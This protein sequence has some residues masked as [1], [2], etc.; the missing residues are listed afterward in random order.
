MLTYDT[1]KAF[2]YPTISRPPGHIVK[3]P[4][5]KGREL[6]HLLPLIPSAFRTYYDPFVGGGAMY[7]A[8]QEYGGRRCINDKS[9]ELVSIYKAVA[10]GSPTFFHFL[11]TL[12]QQWANISSFANIHETELLFLSQ[13]P[14]DD[15]K[16]VEAFVAGYGRE[17]CA[18]I[19]NLGWGPGGDY[20]LS[21]VKNNLLSKMKR[22]SKI[23]AETRAFSKQD[24]L[25]AMECALK[26]AFYGYVRYM[27][28]HQAD[29]NAGPG[30][31]T[32]TFF[33]IRETTYSAMFR[34]NHVGMFNAPYA[35]ASY[36]KKRLIRKIAF[37]RAE[38]TQS[39]L[40]DTVITHQDFLD[41][42]QA[43]RLDSQDFVFLDPPYLSQ[44]SSYA[45]NE[46]SDRDHQRLATYLRNNCPAKFM[47][48]INNTPLVQSLYANFP[49]RSFETTYQVNFQARNNRLASHLIITN[50]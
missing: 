15:E 24:R 1:L 12:D 36:N 40:S 45:Q 14:L 8:L 38:A 20:F 26:S 23:E 9:T 30:E 35:G 33:F 21:E 28:N 44:F 29:F 47:L 49:I 6:K 50:Y 19:E 17:L 31:K 2:P 41:F 48:V 10:Q 42:L 22:I 11:E 16:H 5:G 3:W 32:A 4:G 27:Y 43:Q 46:F 39:Y 37:L 25:A 7:L 34:Y 13:T 18:L